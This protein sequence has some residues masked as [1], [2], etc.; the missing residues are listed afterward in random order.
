MKDIKDL[1]D[2]ETL[3]EKELTKRNK[4]IQN[5]IS[6]I[7]KLNCVI[8]A[9]AAS[10][11]FFNVWSDYNHYAGSQ[12]VMDEVIDVQ[13]ASNENISVTYRYNIA[14]KEYESNKVQHLKKIKNGDKEE[15]RVKKDSPEVI[16]KYNN[17]IFAIFYDMTLG[18]C[19]GLTVVFFRLCEMTNCMLP[20]DVEEA[21]VKTYTQN[22]ILK[23]ANKLLADNRKNE[24]ADDVDKNPYAAGVHDGI[25]YVLTNLKIDSKEKFLN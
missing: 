16:F 23:I 1:K 13:G 14:G 9:I 4:R 21:G 5:T 10:L 20:S 2:M 25:L 12:L 17:V 8:V 6:L 15:I 19:I 18:F 24:N 11:T 22:E 7:R 3:R